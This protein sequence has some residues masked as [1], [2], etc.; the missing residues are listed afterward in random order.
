MNRIAAILMLVLVGCHCQPNVKQHVSFIRLDDGSLIQIGP[1]ELYVCPEGHSCTDEGQ[2]I[3]WY[4]RGSTIRDGIC[5]EVYSLRSPFSYWGGENH[6]PDA[7]WNEA[8][9]SRVAF[10]EFANE[11]DAVAWGDSLCPN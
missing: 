11:K 7:P 2:F 6:R 1:G 8:T 4:R 9:K 10:A 3:Y 5:A